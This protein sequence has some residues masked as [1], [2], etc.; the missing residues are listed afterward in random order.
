[1]ELIDDLWRDL[2]RRARMGAGPVDIALDPAAWAI[3]TYRVGRAIEGLPA[4][5]RLPLRALH[6]PLAWA[7]GHATGIRLPLEAEIGGGLYLAHTGNVS[8]AKDAR[9]GRDCSLSHGATIAGGGPLI[10]DRVC[11][12]P[13]ARVEG[14]VRVGNDAAIGPGVVVREDVPDEGALGCARAV[15]VRGRRRP[16]TSAAVRALVRQTLPKP[17]HLLLREA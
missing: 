8:I 15:T 3:A 17:A 13:G 10:G 16:E 12:G 1:M 14:A 5:L 4:P 11:I 2:D 9:L 7:L 6:R